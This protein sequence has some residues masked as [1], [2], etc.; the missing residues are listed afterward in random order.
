MKD[1]TKWHNIELVNTSV[2]V[3]FVYKVTNLINNK[4]YI[5]SKFIINSRTKRYDKSWT[6]YKT[7]S[8]YVKTDIVLLGIQNFKF[9]I[10]KCYDN[11]D[12]LRLDEINLIKDLLKT[13]NCYNKNI[14]GRIVMDDVVAAKIRNTFKLRGHP[15]KGKIHPNKGKRIDSG[16]QLNKGKKYYNN[17]QYNKIDFP[18]N[19]DTSVWKEGMI[20]YQT[21]NPKTIEKELLYSN[22]PSKCSICNNNLTY[23]KRNN[24]VCSKKCSTIFIKNHHTK[25]ILE[26]NV[27]FKNSGIIYITPNGNFRIIKKAAAANNV[28]I[29]TVVSRCSNNLTPIKYNRSIPKE[30]NGLTW[31]EL[32]WDRKVFAEKEIPEE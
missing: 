12:D 3:G 2:H 11:Y 16:H 23:K 28:S 8:D 26:K 13:D 4:C 6:V 29:P 7:S 17:G 27:P 15:M 32:G 30:W 1:L 9:E 21:K 14:G 25:Y 18:E 19:V 5:G 24:K 22:S 31:K 20:R 10:I